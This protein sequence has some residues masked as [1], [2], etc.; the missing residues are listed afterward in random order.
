MPVGRKL[1]HVFSN[2]QESF[3]HAGGE[4]EKGTE[5][6]MGTEKRQR[7]RDIQNE[8]SRSDLYSIKATRSDLCSITSI[9]GCLSF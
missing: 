5:G 6:Q 2:T 1:G 3:A 8:G 4:E 7:D 9:R